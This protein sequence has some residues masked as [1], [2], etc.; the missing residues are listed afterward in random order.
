MVKLIHQIWVGPK[1]P[2]AR[3]IENSEM[4]ER[5]NTDYKMI[6]WDNDK[7][8]EEFP[9]IKEFLDLGCVPVYITNWAR[10]RIIEKYGGWYIDYDYT[11]LAPLEQLLKDSKA[12]E[13]EPYIGVG[14]EWPGYNAVSGF[15]Y[16]DKGTDFAELLDYLPDVQVMP[17]Y[18]D[19]N[20]Q[21]DT[22]MIPVEMTSTKGTHYVEERMRSFYAHEHF[23]HRLIKENGK[24]ELVHKET[25][26]YIKF[27]K[28]NK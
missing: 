26:K 24:Y 7:L 19:W 17:M 16:G 10:F 11:P 14:F 18:N 20:D 22:F 5:I 12:P 2:P 23:K 27:K 1:G 8:I 21:Y 9:E 25:L 28:E 4:I 15:F 3:F 13:D 6:R